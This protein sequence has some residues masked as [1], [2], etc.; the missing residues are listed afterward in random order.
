MLT[1]LTIKD[2]APRSKFKRWMQKF[3]RNDPKSYIASM[4]GLAVQHII[5][6]Q[7][8]GKVNWDKIE[9]ALLVPI[10]RKFI[11]CV[12]NLKLPRNLGFER[13]QSDALLKRL[14]ENAALWVLNAAKIPPSDIKI[15]IY[16][17]DG[18]ELELCELLIP[19]T[20]QLR[21]ITKDIG[22]YYL[23]YERLM[24]EYGVAVMISSETEWLSF[25]DVVITP[26]RITENLPFKED[27]IIFS[28]ERPAVSAKG[29]IFYDYQMDLAE[30]YLKIMPYDLPDLY[31]AS[32]LYT[33]GKQYELGSA[34][35][36]VIIGDGFSILPD[37]LVEYLRRLIKSA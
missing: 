35:P 23:E 1:A 34:V 27:A 14:A 4:Q 20:N 16:D 28:T 25:C 10:E 17:P 9:K 19:F 33:K 2:A 26:R 5:Y 29:V 3:S 11:L 13:F 37:N 6:E 7:I 15:A 30:K 24:D 32:A 22:D 8:N 21:I 12:E 36:S 18:S 31:F